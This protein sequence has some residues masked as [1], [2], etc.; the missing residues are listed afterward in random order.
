[1]KCPYCEAELDIPKDVME[2]EIIS[3]S[4]CGLELEYKNGE[5]QQLVIDGEDWGEL[6]GLFKLKGETNC[7]RRWKRKN[8]QII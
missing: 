8:M 7:Y 3:C 1:M 2:G 4:G 5:F 6:I